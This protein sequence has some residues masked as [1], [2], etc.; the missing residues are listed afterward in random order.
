MSAKLF[1]PSGTSDQARGGER[2]SPSQV[3]RGGILPW[4]SNALLV[5]VIAYYLF[6]FSVWIMR[7]RNEILVR[8]RQTD[9]VR[10]WLVQQ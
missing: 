6:F 9:W 8:E 1:A 4:F 10:Q 2:S 5:M 7:I 3:C